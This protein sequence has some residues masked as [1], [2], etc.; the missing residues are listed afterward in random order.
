MDRETGWPLW[1]KAYELSVLVFTIDQRSIWSEAEF[2]KTSLS[3]PAAGRG[4]QESVL[5]RY[6]QNGATHA[7]TL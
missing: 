4:L 5:T 2:V 7:I 3:Q 6:K 1:R